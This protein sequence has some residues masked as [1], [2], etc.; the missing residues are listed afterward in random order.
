M[1]FNSMPRAI[2]RVDAMILGRPVVPDVM[3]RC[4]TSG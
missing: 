1:S 4:S 3:I 2:A